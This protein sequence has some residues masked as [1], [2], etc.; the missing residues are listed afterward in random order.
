MKKKPQYFHIVYISLCLDIEFGH[1]LSTVTHPVLILTNTN[2]Q[3]PDKRLTVMKTNSYSRQII[4]YGSSLCS[5]TFLLSISPIYQ[6][7]K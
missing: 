2:M 7:K 3:L 5:Y 6:K 1:V 4:S